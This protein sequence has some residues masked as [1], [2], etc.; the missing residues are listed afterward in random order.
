VLKV[1]GELREFHVVG[2][3]LAK[4]NEPAPPLYKMRIFAPNQIVA[5]SRFWYY[6]R[7]LKKIKKANGEIVDVKEVKEGGSLV[8]RNYGVWLRYDSRTGTHNMYREYRD[9]TVTGAV[10]QCYRD[11]G[12]RHR[13]RADSIQILKAQQIA[14]KDCKRAHV[15]Q[16]HNAKLRFPL[17]HRV[18]KRRNL[19]Q[20]TTRRPITNYV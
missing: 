8:V 3:R 4:P 16:F 15:T 1:T 6:L 11:M 7:F 2:R 19:P 14:A 10:T 9:V 13:A 12:A 20:F 18:T 5:K 17:T